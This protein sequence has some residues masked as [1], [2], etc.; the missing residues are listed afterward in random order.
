MK[1]SERDRVGKRKRG[2]VD[3]GGPLHL[4]RMLAELQCGLQVRTEWMDGWMDE[5]ASH[6][7]VAS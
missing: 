1:C 6:R 7:D 5:K 3:E 4:G 2:G